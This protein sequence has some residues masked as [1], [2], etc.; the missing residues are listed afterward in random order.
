MENKQLRFGCP[1]CGMRLVVD[2]SLAGVE[3][4]CP[5]CGAKIIAPPLA[6]SDRLDSRTAA[7]VAI[8]PRGVAS[9]TGGKEDVPSAA[10][11]RAVP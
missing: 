10:P 6:V 3:G 4:P 11:E 2:P 8:K 9:S 1:A 5:S 7:P